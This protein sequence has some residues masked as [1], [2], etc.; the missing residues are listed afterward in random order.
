MASGYY[1]FLL[2][3]RTR[4][5]GSK[6]CSALEQS[7]KIYCFVIYASFGQCRYFPDRSRVTIVSC[8]LG[9]PQDFAMEN[10]CSVHY[11]LLDD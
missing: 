10:L 5:T 9:R 2:H 3:F 11:H 4:P 8:F 1:Y 7:H 6:K